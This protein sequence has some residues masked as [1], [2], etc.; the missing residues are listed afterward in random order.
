MHNILYTEHI[1]MVPCRFFYFLE[2]YS[3][4]ISINH[5]NLQGD[6][7]LTVLDIELSEGRVET[8]N[9]TRVKSRGKNVEWQDK[10]LAA[11]HTYTVVL[12]HWITVAYNCV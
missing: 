8:G 2:H 1:V 7:N 3:N 12:I 5:L 10:K 6:M 11:N 9:T 4:D